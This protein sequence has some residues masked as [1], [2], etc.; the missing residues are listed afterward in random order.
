MMS[1]RKISYFSVLIFNLFILCNCSTTANLYP[2]QGPLSEIKPLPIIEATVTG[3]AGNTG[4]I[5]LV[6]P[7]GEKCKGKWS[8]AAGS[9]VQVGTVNLFSQYGS[10]FGTGFLVGN[11]PGMNRGEAIVI[12]ENGTVI[13]IEFYTG[14]GTANGFG[15]GKD[16]NGNVYRV[17]F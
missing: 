3:I 17:L 13:E 4:G 6:L 11:N 5:S 16:N 7:S 15:L 9:S 12:G 1:L 2:V 10:I 8:S 14:S